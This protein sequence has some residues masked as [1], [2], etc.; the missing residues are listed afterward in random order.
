V[1]RD[2]VRY[3]VEDGLL[4]VFEGG[5]YPLVAKGSPELLVMMAN[6]DDAIDHVLDQYAERVATLEL[7][8]T[9][10][11]EQVAECRRSGVGSAAIQP[12]RNRAA[13]QSRGRA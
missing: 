11:Q 9:T 12:D 5:L 10:L 2:S 3:Y 6:D 7:L 8:V 1:A 4:V 13:L